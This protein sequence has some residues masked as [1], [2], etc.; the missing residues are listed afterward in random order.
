MI[1]TSDNNVHFDAVLYPNQPLNRTQ[2][3]L[4][5][6]ICTIIATIFGVVFALVGAWPVAGF[7]GLDIVL[8]AFAFKLVRRDASRFERVRI[9]ANGLLVEARDPAGRRRRWSF[10]P[11]WVSVHMDDPPTRKSL[12]TLSSHGRSL[13][14]GAFLTPEDRVSL[15][16]AIQKSLNAFR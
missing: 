6:G 10:E 14:I 7:F 12:I 3:C 13:R 15:A 4:I 1:Q 2:A 5:I 9:D 8:L 16:K 11:Y